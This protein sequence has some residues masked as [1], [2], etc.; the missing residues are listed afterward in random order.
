MLEALLKRLSRPVLKVASSIGIDSSCR[1]KVSPLMSSQEP[2]WWVG[3][4]GG[5]G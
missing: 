1:R 4:N 2:T 5:A 3:G